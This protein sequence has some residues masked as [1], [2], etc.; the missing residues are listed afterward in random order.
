MPPL[1][2]FGKKSSAPS[3]P[4]SL[5]A[6]PAPPPEPVPIRDR[7]LPGFPDFE[8]WRPWPTA[9]VRHSPQNVDYIALVGPPHRPIDANAALRNLVERGWRTASRPTAAPAFG[10]RMGTHRAGTPLRNPAAHPQAPFRRGLGT[11]PANN[12]Q[13]MKLFDQVNAVAFRGDRRSP[14]EI[15]AAGGFHPPATRTDAAYARAIAEGFYLYLKRRDGL[16]LDHDR[17]LKEHWMREMAEYVLRPPTLEERKFFAEYHFWRQVLQ[18]EEMHL[19]KMTNESFLKGYVSTT[20]DASKAHEGA[21]GSLGGSLQGGLTGETGWIYVV[22]V[23]GGFLLKEGV[24][25][26]DKKESEIAHLG[27]VPWDDV[28]GFVH[29][30]VPDFANGGGKYDSTF[31]FSKYF[32]VTHYPQ[33]KQALAQLSTVLG[34]GSAQRWASPARPTAA[35]AGTMLDG[36]ARARA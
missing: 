7:T 30:Y 6:P 28:V 17:D 14:T 3:A 22:K 27:S 16:N 33:F 20:R 25:G 34:L 11:A 12:W 10:S 26:Y 19:L 35:R 13:H 24:Q 1:S 8:A 31:W 9:A 29:R 32:R 5:P 18:G 4:S 2:P 21:A 36:G 23:Y 15:R